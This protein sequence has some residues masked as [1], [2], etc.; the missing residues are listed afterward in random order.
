M[1]YIIDTSII[2]N[3][4]YIIDRI[5][6][7]LYLGNEEAASN[8]NLL[9][10]NGITHILIAGN[11]MPAVFPHHFKYKQIH[12]SDT[13]RENIL[14][15]FDETY[16]FIDDAISSSG[17]ILVHC[18]MSISRS[19]TVVIAYI[20]KKL[21]LS[22][23]KAAYKVRK[24]HPL[25]NPNPAFLRQLLEFDLTLQKARG[26]KNEPVNYCKCTIF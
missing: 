8:L 19:P 16:S 5:I 6:E 9:K 21:N 23:K 15:Y 4:L 14:K 13:L 12:I 26:N 1:D 11:F 2:S 20:M 25:T 7:G 3:P 24:A 18:H 10:S 17:R 22:L